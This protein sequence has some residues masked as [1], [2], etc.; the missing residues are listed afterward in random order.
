VKKRARA[1]SDARHQASEVAA[2][3]AARI[4]SQECLAI[5]ARRLQ[6]AITRI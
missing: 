5:R 6:R 3:D 1:A 4:I 2:I